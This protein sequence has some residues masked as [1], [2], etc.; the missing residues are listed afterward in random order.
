MA[1]VFVRHTVK[2]FGKWR[3]TFE[4]YEPTRRSFGG[5]DYT[6]FRSAQN[7]NDIFLLFSWDSLENARRF[8][9]SDE[10]R[11]AMEKAG[12]VGRPEIHFLEGAN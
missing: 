10:L 11:G 3:S 12:V 5:G 1:H 6:L 2:D 4:A 7:P 9:E 8:I